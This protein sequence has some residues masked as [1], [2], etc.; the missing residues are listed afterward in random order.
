MALLLVMG[1][2]NANP[3]PVKDR[4]GCY[5]LGDVVQV[6]EDGTPRVTKP[7]GPFYIIEISGLSKAAAEKYM[8]P[9]LEVTSLDQPPVMVRRRRFGIPIA[10]VPA[11]IRSALA[12]DRY[13]KVSWAQVRGYVRDKATGAGE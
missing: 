10:A 2:D 8:Q 11:A 9:E 4:R 6:F 12:R 3:D 7:A 1:R 5:K 13:V